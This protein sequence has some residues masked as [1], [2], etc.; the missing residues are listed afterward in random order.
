MIPISNSNDGTGNNNNNSWKGDNGTY[1]YISDV[2]MMNGYVI[3]QDELPPDY[4]IKPFRSSAEKDA[5]SLEQEKPL[6]TKGSL[7]REVCVIHP[8]GKRLTQ[9]LQTDV[10]ETR[11]IAS[12]DPESTIDPA[13]KSRNETDLHQ[14]LSRVQI[15]NSSAV[16]I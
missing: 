2:L 3:F 5:Q 12:N 1:S 11:F 4:I 6:E 14:D 15:A 16:P 13:I 8:N 7:L 9:L 10:Y